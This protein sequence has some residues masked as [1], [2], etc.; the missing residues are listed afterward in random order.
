MI[1]IYWFSQVTRLCDL[2]PNDGVCSVQ[3]TKEGS[4]LSIGTNGGQV[5]VANC[6]DSLALSFFTL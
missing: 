4:Y 5:Q 2:G 1:V 3:W 6:F